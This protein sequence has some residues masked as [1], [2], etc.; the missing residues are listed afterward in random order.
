MFE[1]RLISNFRVQERHLIEGGAYSIK[2]GILG[3]QVDCFAINEA[4]G[5]TSS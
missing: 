1:E 4:V 2:Y 3:E 5:C